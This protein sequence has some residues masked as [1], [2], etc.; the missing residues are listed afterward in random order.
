MLSQKQ[1]VKS[2]LQSTSR[3]SSFQTSCL[4]KT[5]D[6]KSKVQSL[7]AKVNISA[8]ALIWGRQPLNHPSNSY[9]P[10]SSKSKRTLNHKGLNQGRRKDRGSL[11]LNSTKLR[12]WNKSMKKQSRSSRKR[13]KMMKKELN[14]CE[15]GIRVPMIG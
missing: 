2:Q 4:S 13:C 8:R 5:K 15:L 1:Q 11:L 14:N 6:F 12:T 7:S 3:I 9:L 10:K